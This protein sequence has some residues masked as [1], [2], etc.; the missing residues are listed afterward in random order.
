MSVFEVFGVLCQ[1]V[2]CRKQRG[3][4]SEVW[5]GAEYIPQILPGSCPDVDL[6]DREFDSQGNMR[7]HSAV[8]DG[9]SACQFPSPT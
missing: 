8:E 2:M 4:R 9:N 7:L 1:V 5:R 3:R 6:I